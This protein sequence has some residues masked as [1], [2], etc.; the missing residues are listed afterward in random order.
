[1][2]LVF[3]YGT[4]PER[5]DTS[6]IDDPVVEVSIAHVPNGA[7]PRFVSAVVAAYIFFGAA[8]F[9]VLRDF[10]W[11][12]RMRHEF[13]RL[14]LPRNY[15]VFIR[16]IP[17]AYRNNLALE[18]FM[19]SCFSADS[20]LEA[21]VAVTTHQ[22]AKVQENRQTV[23]SQLEHAWAVYEHSG[24]R[25]RHREGGFWRGTRVDSIETYE[26]QLNELNDQVEKG[27]KTIE[28]KIQ[29][30]LSTA[31]E[32]NAIRHVVRSGLASSIVNSSDGD[33][34][35]DCELQLDNTA[36]C[37][38]ENTSLVASREDDNGNAEH[39]VNG[40]LRA[41]GQIAS[42]AVEH[43]GGAI[44]TVGDLATG[45]VD[46]AA[47]L[48]TGG[49]DGNAHPAGFVVFSKLSTA[50]AALQMVHHPTPF[51]ME[52][53]EA[54]DPKD[55]KSTS[56]TRQKRNHNQIQHLFYFFQLNGSIFREH[57]SH[58]K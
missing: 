25:P 16:N 17:T 36:N 15:A 49:E 14:K 2:W 40:T 3:V 57:T 12:T 24:K 39:P 4:A 18:Q 5:S 44:Q 47:T 20:V 1:M 32:W 9:L 42:D 46:G 58:C 34:R 51:S 56:L 48:I 6:D 54:P 10:A 7:W 8:M 55:S 30:R 28:D 43:V 11:Y 37:S 45:A 50:N 31:S 27:M 38:D 21:H 35:S 19:K 52:I 29:A 41:V 22:L 33:N 53:S 26:R 13:L 23:Q